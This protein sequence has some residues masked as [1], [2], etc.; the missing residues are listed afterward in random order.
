MRGDSLLVQGRAALGGDVDVFGESVLERVAGEAV[1]AGGGERG[2]VGLA[3]AFG[4]PDSRTAVV[5]GVSGVIR[6]FRPFPVQRTCG[7]VAR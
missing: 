2:L 5:V 4:E 6:F 3:G 1:A 7:P